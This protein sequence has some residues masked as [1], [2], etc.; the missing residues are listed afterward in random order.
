MPK[1]VILSNQ[2]A[3]MANFWRKLILEL[4]KRDFEI[5]CLVP[6]GDEAAGRLVELGASVKFYPL[7]RKGLNPLKDLRTFLS[8]KRSFSEIKPDYL[9]ATTIKPVIYGCRAAK[10]V[11]VPC[12]FATITGLGYAFESDSFLKKILHFGAKTLYR[13][14]LKYAAGIFFQNG[15]DRDLFLAQKIISP[16]AKIF[17]AKGTGVDTVKFS[18]APFPPVKDG[19]KFLVVARLLAAKGLREYASAAKKLAAKYPR[20]RFCLLGPEEKGPGGISA[21]EAKGWE[22]DGVVY[23]GSVDD[24]RPVVA[25]SHVVVLPSWREGVPTVLMEAASMGRPCVAADVPGSRE[26]IRDSLNGFL[27]EVKNPDSLASAMEKFILNPELIPAMGDAG[28]EIAAK[29]F[30]ADRVASFIVD[31]MLEACENSKAG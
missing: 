31:N 25:D 3:S 28:R 30:D 1:I 26:I 12:V 6:Q 5:I 29:E 7:D 2:A 15:D 19:L 16:H 24:P 20:T 22:K 27:C 23:L 13:E 18:P 10:A 21:S 4:Q 11:G 17:I 14:S 8:L 9:F